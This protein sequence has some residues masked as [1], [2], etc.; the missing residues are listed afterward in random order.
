MKEEQG[1]A[2]WPV[3]KQNEAGDGDRNE[4]GPPPSRWQAHGRWLIGIL[5][6]LGVLA[7]LTWD[8]HPDVV[9]LLYVAI[10]AGLYRW[11]TTTRAFPGPVRENLVFFV[12]V[13]GLLGLLWT[14]TGFS[15][16]A[17]IPIMLTILVFALFALGLNL[18][19]GYTGIINF[20]HVAFMGIGAYT[21]AIITLRWA[22]RAVVLEQPGGWSVLAVGASVV[23][24]FLVFGVIA[25]LIVETVMY[26]GEVPPERRRRIQVMTGLAA[27]FVGAV[28]VLV[29]VPWPL[30]PMW[31]MTYFLA[32][33]ALLGMLLAAVAGLLL[34]LPTLRLRADYLAIVT[35]GAAEILRRAWLNEAWLTRGPM[36]ISAR[37]GQR[38][39]DTMFGEWE[40]PRHVASVID[41]V[42]VYTVVLLLL[43]L[44]VV[45]FVFVSYQIL[46]RSPYGRVLR[47]VR[48]DEDLAAALG[49]NV[50][51]YKLQVL[52]IGGAVAAL[53][54]AFLLWQRQFVDPNTFHPLITFY[55]WIIVVVGGAGN[56]KGTILGAVVL[57][58]FFE[59]TRFLDLGSALGLTSPQVG[60]L[61]IALI[62]LLLILLMLFKPEG[63]LGKREELVLGD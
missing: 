31:A 50:F 32:G 34:G 28:L 3:E 19:F 57:W 20:G 38:P 17:M 25:T 24:A 9:L 63:I 61:R 37:T 11:L 55:A 1:E 46:S 48:E 45:L 27:G 47:A 40:W 33:A 26:R 15:N 43:L 4:P 8:G 59:A 14:M 35:I 5:V 52:A 51:S 44:V 16:A 10:L 18:Q 49:K 6:L 54:G 30:T 23:F 2:S 62:G 56:N 58:T 36:G 60:A 41:A 53:A 21:V 22:D 29:V 7:W 42:S 39:F 12:L 13:F